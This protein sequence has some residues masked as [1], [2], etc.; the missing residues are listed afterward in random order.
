[1]AQGGLDEQERFFYFV[2]DDVTDKPLRHRNRILTRCGVVA[3]SDQ[4]ICPWRRRF[5]FGDAPVL[6]H[7]NATPPSHPHGRHAWDPSI[8]PVVPSVSLI[9]LQPVSFS[10]KFRHDVWGGRH[11]PP[12]RNVMEDYKR[13]ASKYGIF[14]TF[15]LEQQGWRTDLFF[16]L[17]WAYCFFL[18]L[19]FPPLSPPVTL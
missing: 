14:H 11:W 5:S 17:L 19:F 10:C 1:M 3:Q 12:C 4:D 2:R 9:R 6:F 15:V 7:Q 13:T 8:V 16:F 18:S